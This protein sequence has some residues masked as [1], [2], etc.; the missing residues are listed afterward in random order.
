[1]LAFVIDA[2]ATGLPTGRVLSRRAC[3]R[4]VRLFQRAP[5]KLNAANEV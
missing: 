3:D 2:P 4:L 5:V 1:M